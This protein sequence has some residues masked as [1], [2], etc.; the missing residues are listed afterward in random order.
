MLS[1]KVTLMP[2]PIS[3]AAS[4]SI[5]EGVLHRDLGGELV[6]LNNNSGRYFG[7]DAVGARMWHAL[8]QTDSIEHACKDLL[9][10]FD[11]DEQKL[12]SDLEKLVG[13][14]SNRGLL[15]VARAVEHG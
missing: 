14:L 11:V 7:L 4:V 2:V 13:E 8:D 5:P 3:F 6:I 12:R 15:N 1:L 10:E 9:A